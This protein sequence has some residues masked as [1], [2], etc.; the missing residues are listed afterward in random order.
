MT[1]PSGSNATTKSVPSRS[2]DTLRPRPYPRDLPI[3]S[4]TTDI[5]HPWRLIDSALCR[6]PIVRQIRVHVKGTLSYPPIA[7]ADAGRLVNGTQVA[8]IQAP[9]VRPTPQ[10]LLA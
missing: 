6:V 8:P 1:W 2:T 5:T 7:L 3:L 10:I 9:V 4:V